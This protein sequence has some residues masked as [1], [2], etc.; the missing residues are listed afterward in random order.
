MNWWKRENIEILSP[1]DGYNRWASTYQ[2]ESNPIKNLSD[3]LVEKLLPDIAGK[4]FLDSGCGTGKFITYAQK[5]KASRIVGIDLSPAMI[6]ICRKVC[7]EADLTCD[8]INKAMI[9]T[10][11]FDVVVT[12]LMMAHLENI[13]P[14]IESLLGAV[15]K[16]G[17]FIITDFH[18]Y[19]TLLQ[20]KRTFVDSATGKKFEIKHHLHLFEEYFH[21]FSQMNMEVERFEEPVFN[22]TPVIFGIR[23]RK[24]L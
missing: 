7:P 1:L 5:N 6:E 4:S 8:D 3:Q 12:A 16:G 15:K 2:Q 20:S 19:L 24:K 13:Q 22:N 21:F 17:T 23:A 11:S 9:E 18:P 10:N 14:A